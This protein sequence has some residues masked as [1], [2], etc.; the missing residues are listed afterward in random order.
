MET[1]KNQGKGD[2]KKDS[3]SKNAT[4]NKPGDANAKKGVAGKTS[5]EAS[6]GNAGKSS[7][8]NKR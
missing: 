4:T 7:D 5:M 3:T 8:K 1:Q 2:S 6:K